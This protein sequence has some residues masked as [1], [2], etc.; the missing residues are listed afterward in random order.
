MCSIRFTLA[1]TLCLRFINTNIISDFAAARLFLYTTFVVLP[2]Y[3]AER[4]RQITNTENLHITQFFLI[5][6]L[7]THDKRL[8]VYIC[9]YKSNEALSIKISRLM[10]SVVLCYG[11]RTFHFRIFRFSH[12]NN[13][14]TIYTSSWIIHIFEIDWNSCTEDCSLSLSFHK[15]IF[16][17][18]FLFTYRQVQFKFHTIYVRNF[19]CFY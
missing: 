3:F 16:L 2:E 14:R 4:R 15:M 6:N 17:H 1:R 11:E 7:L 13:I 18:S 8:D 19:F 5:I 9:I 12:E 10:L